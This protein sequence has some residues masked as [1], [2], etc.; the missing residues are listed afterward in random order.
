MLLC[1]IGCV[2]NLNNSRSNVANLFLR[3]LS[4][5]TTALSESYVMLDLRSC[6]AMSGV[7]ERLLGTV[8]KPCVQ[9]LNR[10]QTTYA[11]PNER[12]AYVCLQTRSQSTH[13][14]CPH[15]SMYLLHTQEVCLYR[16][17][18]LN[19][20]NTSRNQTFVIV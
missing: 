5:A 11:E 7:T 6:C 9:K 12:S 17:Y 20:S 3:I 19:A 16:L 10:K 13:F 2:C 15:R 14:I 18:L 1:Y 8:G 4:Y